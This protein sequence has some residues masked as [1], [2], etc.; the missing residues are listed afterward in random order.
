MQGKITTLATY[1]KHGDVVHLI[2]SPLPYTRILPS[3][4]CAHVCCTLCVCLEM[5]TNRCVK[6]FSST[7]FR[8]LFFISFSVHVSCVLLLG[9]HY[10]QLLVVLSY[11]WYSLRIR[12]YYQAVVFCRLCNRSVFRWKG[13][14]LCEKAIGECTLSLAYECEADAT[15]PSRMLVSNF[16]FFF[17]KN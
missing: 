3:T 4:R 10:F 15:T 6:V 9:T 17:F 16:H 11:A 2:E 14:E 1:I 8:F 12:Y 7:F 5:H 13:A